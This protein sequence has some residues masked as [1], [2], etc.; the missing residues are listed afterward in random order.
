MVHKEM[1]PVAS[2]AT[3]EELVT[4]M[5]LF[6]RRHTRIENGGWDGGTTNT[7]SFTEAQFATVTPLYIAAQ[8]PMP[9]KVLIVHHQPEPQKSQHLGYEIVY[10]QETYPEHTILSGAVLYRKKLRAHGMKEFTYETP[11]LGAVLAESETASQKSR[12]SRLLSMKTKERT[13][14]SEVRAGFLLQ[15][16]QS[17]YPIY[18]TAA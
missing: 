4:A 11:C 17:A 9:E 6:S 3:Q 8:Y 5:E 16:V 15:V 14:I 12:F 2:R 18:D 7:A 13:P 1:L 10:M